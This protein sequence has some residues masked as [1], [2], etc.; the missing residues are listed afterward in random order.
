MKGTI[1]RGKVTVKNGGLVAL[2]A[3]IRE[4]SA[5]SRQAHLQSRWEP[6]NKER[7]S[8]RGPKGGAGRTMK[9]FA[10]RPETHP[11]VSRYEGEGGGGTNGG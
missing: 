4:R 2:A 1:E 10:A 9:G 6:G 3:S 8:H 7:A 5:S 11:L